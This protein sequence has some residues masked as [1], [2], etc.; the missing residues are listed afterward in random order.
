MTEQ[1]QRTN[2]SSKFKRTKTKNE[3]TKTSGPTKSTKVTSVSLTHSLDDFALKLLG[4]A[5]LADALEA[6]AVGAVRKDAEAALAGVGLLKYHL[7]A[8]AAHHVLAALH[9]EGDLHVL[10][11]GFDARLGWREGDRERERN[12]W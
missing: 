6:V 12:R 9:S 1:N 7:H 8:H 5:P 2:N 11:M 10:L 4:A 3:E